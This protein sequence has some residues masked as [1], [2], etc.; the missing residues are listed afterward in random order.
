[1]EGLDLR[2]GASTDTFMEKASEVG[3]FWKAAARWVPGW[4]GNELLGLF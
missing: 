1:M 4:S 2:V 3:A